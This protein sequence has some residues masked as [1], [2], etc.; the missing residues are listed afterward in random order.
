LSRRGTAEEPL[1]RWRWQGY[2]SGFRVALLAGWLAIYLSSHA[3][4]HVEA[5]RAAGI[6]FRAYG[7]R[8]TDQRRTTRPASAS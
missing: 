7:L 3:I 5:G 4:A 8:G 2:D 6:R 1:R